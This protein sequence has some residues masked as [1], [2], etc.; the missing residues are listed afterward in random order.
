[1][2]LETIIASRLF[3]LFV[4][5]GVSA[6]VKNAA[7]ENT[8][9]S[10][11]GGA[12][13]G[14]GVGGS[15]ADLFKEGSATAFENILNQISRPHQ[16]QLNHHLNRAARK[17]Q[18]MATFF[19]C[20]GCLAEIEADEGKDAEQKWLTKLEQSLAKRTGSIENENLNSSTVGEKDI[21]AIFN[22]ENKTVGEI[23]KEIIKKFHE[24]TFALIR[25]DAESF[26][27][28]DRKGFDLLKNCIENGWTE[29][30]NPT[31]PIK[32]YDWFSLLCGAFNDEYKE[33]QNFAAMQKIQNRE[34]L[35]KISE[36]LGTNGA[37]FDELCESLSRTEG[38]MDSLTD[39]IKQFWSEANLKLD[40]LA[41]VSQEI[42]ENTERSA[43]AAEKDFEQRFR[44]KLAQSEV[45]TILGNFIFVRPTRFFNREEELKSLK[46]FVFENPQPITVIKGA[47]GYGKTSLADYFLKEIAPHNKI[48]DFETV[49]EIVIFNGQF[50]EITFG[51]IFDRA[52]EL[53]ERAFKVQAENSVLREVFKTQMPDEQ[54]LS[55]LFEQLARI[56]KVWF[57]FD[58]F[59]S[60][61]AEN[62]HLR[63]E[64]LKLFLERA[65]KS[66]DTLRLI[67]TTREVPV[68]EG[69]NLVSLLEM[70]GQL[71]PEDAVAYLKQLATSENVNWR[72]SSEDD[73]E[74]LLA[75]LSEKLRYI[76]KAL[77]S[78]AD[79]FKQVRERPLILKKV[80]ENE[81]LFA[82]FAKYDLEKGY[83]KLV[84]EQFECLNTL[85]KAVWFALAV[86]KEPVSP[87]ALKFVLS[88]YDLTNIWT[89]LHGSG[90]IVVEEREIDGELYYL[91]SLDQSAHDYV[92]NLLP[93]DGEKLSRR[94]LHR[95]AAEFYDSIRQPIKDCYTREQFEPYFN[96]FD[97]YYSAG[98]YI[99][100]MNLLY[101][102]ILKLCDLGYSKDII[103]RCQ[104]L[105]G[106]LDKD[107][108]EA[109]N[110]ANLG[111]ALYVLSRLNEAIVQY[112]KAIAIREELVREQKREGL[113]RDLA[114]VYLNKGSA[115]LRLGKLN[116]ALI[117]NDKTIAIYEK[118]IYEQGRQELAE[119]LAKGY[120]G[121]G[122]TLKDLG[123]PDEAISQ[124]DKA[125]TIFEDLV[126]GQKQE[127]LADDL[128]AVYMNKG[129]ALRNL[130][131]PKEAI[132]EYNKAIAI[133]EELVIEQKREELQGNLAM[134]YVNKGSSL[135][136]LGRADEAVEEYNKSII[137]SEKL[138]NTQKRE[139]LSD[140]LA[141][142]YWGKALIL[143]ELSRF[144]E[145]LVIYDEAIKI[146]YECLKREETQILPK[147]FT[148]FY[149]K[150][151]SLID[152]EKWKKTSEHIIEAFNVREKAL[153][154]YEISQHFTD[155]IQ[156]SWNKIIQL[157]RSLSVENRE[158][159]Y[160]NAGENGKVIRRLVEGGKDE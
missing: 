23:E 31:S 63:D 150:T 37:S 29:Q 5:G 11:I 1:M 40:D 112:D 158:E 70:K 38:K 32:K 156:N 24:D 137:I 55:L 3:T 147:L 134:A 66:G 30:A 152:L 59:E 87:E 142:S 139:E 39:F 97:H 151:E 144:D 65:E 34:L 64:N 119:K 105:E 27:I 25:T 15:I 117:E 51:K 50:G 81:N 28:F 110:F 121:K 111:L 18:L 130:N 106:K 17:A 78:F 92:Y 22:A 113:T 136:D 88:E 96:A 52:A 146:W 35:D 116:E 102:D 4:A 47:G 2:A 84:G 89:F 114:S 79:Y 19:A 83:A 118:L 53:L 9:L 99:N 60:V 123:R 98:H 100:A 57:F 21:S 67:L 13:F 72:F 68:F 157:I 93:E 86:F 125:I 49:N 6:I 16:D 148:V 82:D 115:L 69:A 44:E 43:I 133:R 61:L 42:K 46:N 109:V 107:E 138:V 8:L 128:A 45:G 12:S 74:K 132:D 71:P 73:E 131:R 77:F 153:N 140:Y 122:I 103:N 58:N 129:I 20:R 149:L 26:P 145:A 62:N 7:G 160:Q 124:Y 76:P 54:R 10:E 143:F 159:I 154:E 95:R 75:D 155:Q 56:G 141:I 90:L 85:E 91:F 14:E 94:E 127:K 104:L 101:E 48:S 80:L 126:N 108:L 41:K 120:W 36:S 33:T 135:A